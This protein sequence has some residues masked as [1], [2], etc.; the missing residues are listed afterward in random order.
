[1]GLKFREQMPFKI[2][3]WLRPAIF[4]VFF[5]SLL[6]FLVT[7]SFGLHICFVPGILFFMVFCS[8]TIVYVPFGMIVMARNG[9]GIS[10]KTSFFL[11]ILPLVREFAYVC[12]MC[13]GFCKGRVG[14]IRPSWKERVDHRDAVSAEK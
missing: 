7:M 6:M 9:D 1:M 5:I 4:A 13:L 8:L 12:G 10:G 3:L 11:A 14:A 2:K